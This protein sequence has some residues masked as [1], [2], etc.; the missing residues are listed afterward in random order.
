MQRTLGIFALCNGISFLISLYCLS[1]CAPVTNWRIRTRM[2][3]IKINMYHFVGCKILSDLA[4]MWKLLSLTQTTSI[5]NILFNSLLHIIE[6]QVGRNLEW[7]QH[8]P[9]PPCNESQL[10][11]G[12][13]FLQTRE[14]VQPTKAYPFY[15]YLAP[16][17]FFIYSAENCCSC[18]SQSLPP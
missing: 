7:F 10:S 3:E 16:P 4:Q 15:H 6:P 8:Q 17:I 12:L 14:N 11:T 1:Q 5:T 13:C 18:C 9:Y 2:S